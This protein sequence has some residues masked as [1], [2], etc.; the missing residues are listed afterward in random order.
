MVSVIILPLNVAPNSSIPSNIA[1]RFNDLCGL[2]VFSHVFLLAASIF[3]ETRS[4]F[5]RSSLTS[6]RCR[7][8]PLVITAIFISNGL[9]RSI[10]SPRLISRV[11]SPSG[12][13]DK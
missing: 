10:F 3:N 2:S 4:A 7:R 11:G 13:K 12:T 9:T 5:C 8:D 1:L 6:L